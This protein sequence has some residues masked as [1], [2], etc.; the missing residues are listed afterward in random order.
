MAKDRDMR[1]R[2]NALIEILHAR[3]RNSEWSLYSICRSLSGCWPS[4]AAVTPQGA[5][6][7]VNLS[8]RSAPSHDTIW[9]LNVDLSQPFRLSGNLTSIAHGVAIE[10]FLS[11]RSAPHSNTASFGGRQSLKGSDRYSLRHRRRTCAATSTLRSLKGSCVYC[12]WHRHWQMDHP[13]ATPSL[14]GSDKYDIIYSHNL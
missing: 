4:C 5:A 9:S 6:H 1:N 8:R 10:H 3:V 2:G 7:R 11:R 13:I 14:K 12:R